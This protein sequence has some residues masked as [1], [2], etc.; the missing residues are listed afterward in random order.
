MSQD[1]KI[2]N[3][4]LNGIVEIEYHKSS[5]LQAHRKTSQSLEIQLLH[6]E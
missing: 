1:K 3:L 4:I 6:P 2:K 5:H